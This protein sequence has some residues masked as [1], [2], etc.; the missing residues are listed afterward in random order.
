M[1]YKNFDENE[2]LAMLLDKSHRSLGNNLQR[3]FKIYGFD[4][5]V[6][7]WMIL[8]VLW[9]DNGQ[10]QKQIASIIGK[11]KGT[12][13]PQLDGL[14]KRELIMRLQ[15]KNDKRRNV[16][17]LTQKGKDLENELIPLGYANINIAQYGIAEEDMKTCMKVLR[18]I[19]SNLEEGNVLIKQVGIQ[20]PE[21][22]KIPVLEAEKL[23]IPKS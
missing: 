4:I 2:S 15:D 22:A 12:I 5:T 23:I 17:C 1:D 14:E 16:V 6:E 3:I 7:Q 18:N 13:S 19:C 10:T 8:L 20:R 21:L 9:K 11:D